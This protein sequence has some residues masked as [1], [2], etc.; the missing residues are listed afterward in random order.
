MKSNLGKNMKLKSLTF[1][2][3]M[4]TG[5]GVT[6]VASATQEPV[7]VPAST[8]SAVAASALTQVFTP[9]Q[10]ARIGEVSQEYLL[11]HPELLMEVS[12]K[13]DAQ[14]RAQQLSTITQAVLRHQDALLMDESIP[15]YGPADAKV[16]FVEFFDYQCSVCAKEAPVIRSLMKT[17]PQVRYVFQEWPIFAQ[18]WKTSLS[19]ANTGLQIWAEKGSDKYM[20]YHNAL[21]DTGHYEG[22]L[23]KRDIKAAAAKAVKLKGSNADKLEV[24]SRTDSLAQSLGLR[25]TPSM[26]VMP[27]EGANKDNVTI[28]PGG[29]DLITLQAAIDKAIKG[30]SSSTEGIGTEVKSRVSNTGSK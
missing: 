10:E 23:T 26:I 8:T 24:L 11:K 12:R 20:D 16:A 5:G 22:K 28:I 2:I 30:S 1:T 19:A 17:N 14:L 4:V 27:V 29:A 3:M 13:L 15:S 18:R 21:F 6:T 9:E 25:G 7:T